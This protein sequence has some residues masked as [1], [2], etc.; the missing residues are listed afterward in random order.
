MNKKIIPNKFEKELMYLRL[1]S[2]RIWK[3]LHKQFV[4]RSFL[5]SRENKKFD[6]VHEIK[7]NYKVNYLTNRKRILLP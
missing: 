2:I 4:I 7:Y 6:N 1:S 5:I 3:F